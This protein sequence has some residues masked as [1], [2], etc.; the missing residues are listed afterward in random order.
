MGRSGPA[1]A[2]DLM[3]RKRALVVEDNEDNRRILVHRLR[4]MAGGLEVLEA[5]HGQEALD[6][7]AREPLD[8]IF[9]DLKLPVMDGWEAVRR[10]RAL[11]GPMKNVPIVAVTAQAM[12]GDREKALAAGCDDYITKPILDASVIEEKLARYLAGGLG[13]VEAARTRGLHAGSSSKGGGRHPP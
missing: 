13:G 9:M 7:V 1:I 3:N 6:I 5:R 11:D 2:E 8:V 4:R 12:D 10:I